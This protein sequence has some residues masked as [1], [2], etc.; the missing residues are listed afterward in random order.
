MRYVNT[1]KLRSHHHTHTHRSLLLHPPPLMHR[2]S[3]VTKDGNRRSVTS[4]LRFRQ[5]R[6]LGKIQQQQQQQQSTPK[7]YFGYS[8]PQPPPSLRGIGGRTLRCFDVFVICIPSQCTGETEGGENRT[9]IKKN[10][11]QQLSTAQQYYIYNIF[12]KESAFDRRKHS[13]KEGPRPPT[14]P[15]PPQT[16]HVV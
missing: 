16:E 14:H 4:T 11:Q 7:A 2:V 10:D 3:H 13:K 9:Y 15:P 6:S 5:L 8:P 12:K 1:G